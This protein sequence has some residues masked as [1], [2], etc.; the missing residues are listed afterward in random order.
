[1]Y[2]QPGPWFMQRHLPAILLCTAPTNCYSIECGSGRELL[3]FSPTE[4]DSFLQKIIK[5]L[6][7]Y[8]KGARINMI[9]TKAIGLVTHMTEKESF[10]F[11]STKILGDK[12]RTQAHSFP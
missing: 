6:V 1:M 12:L 2:S 7:D 5:D 8:R 10:L 11:I 3:K 4:M 9:D